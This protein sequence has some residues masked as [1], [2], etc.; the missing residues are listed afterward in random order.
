MTSITQAG[1]LNTTALAVPDLYVQIVSPQTLQLNGVPTNVLG[2]VGTASWGPVNQ[3]VIIGN[4]QG[5]YNTFGPV[6][7]RKYDMGTHVSTAIQQGAQNFRCVRITD[8]SDVAATSTGVTTCITFTALYTG[9]QGNNLTVTIGTGSASGTYSAIVAMPGY[10]AEKFDNISGTGN[11]FWVALAAA[12][13]NGTG[14]QRGASNYITATSASG[15]TAVTLG[16]VYTFSGGVDGVSTAATLQTNLIGSDSAT[17][18]TGMYA[19]RSQGCSV[20]LLADL[21]TSTTWSTQAAFGLAEG[22]YMITVSPSGDTISN[23]VST[24][25]TAGLNTYAVKHMFGDWINWL[26]QQNKTYRYVSPQGFVAGRLVNLSPEQS[27]LNKPIYG[28]AGSQ[29]QA[30]GIGNSGTYTSAD[31][32]TLA[33]AGID[34]ITNPGAG[35]VV[36]WCC[37]IGQNTSSDA[38]VNGDNY[39]RLTNYIASTLGAGMGLYVG[40]VI[41]PTLLQ[42]IRATLLSFLGNML[43]QG[44]LGSLTTG[45]PYSVTCD[46]SN[47]PFSRTSLGYVQAD[48][49]V[50]YQAIN[51]FFIINLQGGQTV[52]VTTSPNS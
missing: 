31:L 30:S 21:D 18:R 14:V 46:T 37:R 51:K 10:L 1:S 34:V 8:G 13:N 23:A 43:Q 2:I 48:V 52:Q 26:D 6:M 41:T 22:I 38:T 27:T 17:P 45:L 40:Q 7:A 16:A 44:M 9:S 5:Y 20:A 19:L 28:V 32:Q 39:T 36:Q 15:T 4:A 25:N 50:N 3:P 47:N 12:I 29:K 42:R 11:A 35:G 33:Q 49:A 24:K